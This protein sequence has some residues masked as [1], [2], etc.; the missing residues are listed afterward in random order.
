M[1]SRCEE[2][3]SG[4]GR[5]ILRIPYKHEAELVMDVLRHGA[6]VEVLSPEGLG[7][8]CVTGLDCCRSAV[9]RLQG[10][11]GRADVTS[12]ERQSLNY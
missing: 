5:V 2:R 3:T 4:G 6:N 9:P 7:R 10:G 1:A 12:I 8:G 11:K